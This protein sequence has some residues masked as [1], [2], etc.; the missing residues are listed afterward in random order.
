MDILWRDTGIYPKVGPIDARAAFPMA[1]FLFH[2]SYFTFFLA[3][4]CIVVL[5]LIQRS[6]LT[7]GATIRALK[8]SILIGKRRETRINESVIRKRCR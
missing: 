2:W 8:V 3:I 6:G 5:V 1:I 4:A 7:P